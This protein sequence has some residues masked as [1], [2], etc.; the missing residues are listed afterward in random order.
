MLKN[1]ERVPESVANL[2]GMISKVNTQ[3]EQDALKVESDIQNLNQVSKTVLWKVENSSGMTQQVWHQVAHSVKM[4]LSIAAD[5][6][7]ILAFL[8]N[9]SKDIISKA[10]A[11][12]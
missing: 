8:H 5:L 11:N 4:T 9:F 10:A 7:K 3:R 1:V 6:Q 12:G 2:E